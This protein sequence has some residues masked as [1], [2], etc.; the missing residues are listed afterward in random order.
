MGVCVSRKERGTGEWQ[1]FY[2]MLSIFYAFGCSEGTYVCEPQVCS[3][4][5]GQKRLSN[6][7]ELELQTVVNCLMSVW[8]CIQVLSARAAS[9][10]NY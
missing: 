7:L 4:L 5:G 2:K 10:P 9:T 3:A 1:F 8:D 6:L